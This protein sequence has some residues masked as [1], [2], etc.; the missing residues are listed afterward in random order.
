MNIVIAFIPSDYF[1][2]RAEFIPG[3]NAHIQRLWNGI[4]RKPAVVNFFWN[5]RCAA[6]LE[7]AAFFWRAGIVQQ[8]HWKKIGFYIAVS[9]DLLQ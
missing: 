7:Y 5:Q 4:S 3:F 1:V 2:I 8:H 6:G 9:Q